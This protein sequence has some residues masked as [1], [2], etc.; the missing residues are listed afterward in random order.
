M[1]TLLIIFITAIINF[2]ESINDYDNPF[3]IDL[4]ELKEEKSA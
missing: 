1:T 2:S 3:R 4:D